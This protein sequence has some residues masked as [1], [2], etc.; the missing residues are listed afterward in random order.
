M[1]A[2]VLDCAE[3]LTKIYLIGLLFPASKTKKVYDSF[4]HCL[5]NSQES[6]SEGMFLKVF[7]D[8]ERFHISMSGNVKSFFF[9][10]QE[11]SILNRT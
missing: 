4:S 2:F 3:L 9:L 10:C 11:N 7:Y 6:L 8:P 5:K 1:E